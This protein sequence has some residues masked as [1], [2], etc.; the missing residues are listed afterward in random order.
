[1]RRHSRNALGSAVA[2]LALLLLNTS[3][4]TQPSQK[5]EPASVDGDKVVQAPTSQS[6]IEQPQAKPPIKLE[7]VDKA[8]FENVLANNRGKVV[9]VD[10]W[11]TWCGPCMKSFP[12]TVQLHDKYG[13]DGL[14]VISMSMDDEDAQPEILQFLE[15]QRAHF[16]N[17]RSKSG[18]DPESFEVFDI[19]GGAIPHFKLYDRSGK[20]VRKFVTGEA[21]QTFE[22]HDIEMSVRKLLTE[23]NES[24]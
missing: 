14:A 1:M 9:L 13:P 17:L 7:V 10:F 4:E 6:A 8:G 11:A 23:P 18:S 21:E 12:Q 15:K 3:C 24:K 22:H 20:L 5:Y 16:T 2:A 19:D